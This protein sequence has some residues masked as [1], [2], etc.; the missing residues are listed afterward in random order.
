MGDIYEAF[1]DNINFIRILKLMLIFWHYNGGKQ[2]WSY[3]ILWTKNTS[4]IC[5][6]LEFSEYKNKTIKDLPCS[7]SAVKLLS[8]YNFT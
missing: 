2:K 1:S 7:W 5:E 3:L 6:N 4:Y 8:S